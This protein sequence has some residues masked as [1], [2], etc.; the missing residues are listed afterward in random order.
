M[1]RFSFFPGRHRRTK[2]KP[3]ASL[4]RDEIK[5]RVRI[6]SFHSFLLQFKFLPIVIV[7]VLLFALSLSVTASSNTINKEIT[8]RDV[9]ITL[10][11]EALVPKDANGNPTEPFIMDNSTYLPVRAIAEALGLEVG[12]DGETSTVILTDTKTVYI[13]DNSCMASL[14]YHVRHVNSIIISCFSLS[15]HMLSCYNQ[16]IQQLRD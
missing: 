7:V 10:N 1:R 15:L 16:P 13:G 12:W 4:R 8:Y 2:P 11:G 5:Y 9:K 3:R 6:I 14:F